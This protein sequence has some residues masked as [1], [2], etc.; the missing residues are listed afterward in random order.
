VILKT[1]RLV[2]REFVPGDWRAVHAYQSDPRY[3]RYYPRRD[4]SEADTR[5]FVQRQVDRQSESPRYKFQMAIMLPHNDTLVGNCGVRLD[6]PGALVGDLGYELNPAHWGQG[7]ATEAARAMLA[8][9]FD[10]LGLH[11]VWAECVA[12][13]VA[14]RRVLEKLGMILEGRLRE[15]QYI[16]DRWHDTLIYAVLEQERIDL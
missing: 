7:Y 15:N 4:R 8:F 5:A 10:T 16:D 12:D 14:S 3:Q 6:E 9:G 2:L 1:E 11:R 13:N